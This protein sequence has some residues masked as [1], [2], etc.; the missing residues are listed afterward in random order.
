M[1]YS[2]VMLSFN[3]LMNDLVTLTIYRMRVVK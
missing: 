2:K 1:D 3:L